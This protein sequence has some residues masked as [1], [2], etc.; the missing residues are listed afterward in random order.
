MSIDCCYLSKY[1]CY[2]DEDFHCERLYLI[3]TYIRSENNKIAFTDIKKSVY[4]RKYMTIQHNISEYDSVDCN[5]RITMLLNLQVF[6]E[7]K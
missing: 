4:R 1:D 6:Y 3:N 2:K 7:I 5:E